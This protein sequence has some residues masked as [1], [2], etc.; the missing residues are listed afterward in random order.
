MFNYICNVNEFKSSELK[1]GGILKANEYKCQTCIYLKI[2][3]LSTFHRIPEKFW[4]N[5]G[6]LSIL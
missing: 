3:F 2:R 4:Q 1:R 5:R 6:Q